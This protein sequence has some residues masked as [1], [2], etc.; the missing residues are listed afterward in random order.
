MGPSS[1]QVGHR[2]W[3]RLHSPGA[4]VSAGGPSSVGPSP[5]AVVSAGGRL[6]GPSS[7]GLSPGA[8]VRGAV[9]RGRSQCRRPLSG[10]S[11]L[12]QGAII[13]EAVSSGRGRL[14]GSGAM[15][16]YPPS[17]ELG[18]EVGLSGVSASG[19]GV[20]AAGEGDWWY[21]WWCRCTPLFPGSSY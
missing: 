21:W 18:G 4:V 9:S 6:Q 3:G 12:V 11:L 8:V 15:P 19:V 2:Q 10:G 14:A 1:V 13:S 16:A 20:V 7:V 17:S 5:G